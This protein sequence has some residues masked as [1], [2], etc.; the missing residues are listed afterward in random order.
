MPALQN[1]VLTDRATPTPVN[2]TF[3]P[4][5]GAG[6]GIG[7]LKED[8]GTPYGSPRLTIGKKVT[9]S[10]RHKPTMQF[11]IPTVAVETINGVAVPKV[12]RVA[13]ADITFNFDDQSTAQ[14][15]KNVV[16]MV[17]SALDPAKWTND[18]LVNLQ[19][20]YGI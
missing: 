17:A 7:Q 1:L 13:Y 14:E 19:G 5:T 18:V 10:K 8:T 16:G 11:V 4:D 2:H 20:V 15:R 9:A 12:Q 6:N 3:T